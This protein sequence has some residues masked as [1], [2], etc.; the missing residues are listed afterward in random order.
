MKRKFHLYRFVVLDFLAALIAWILFYILRKKIL[1]EGYSTPDLRLL[2]N[3]LLIGSFWL[4]VYYFFG[5]YSEIYRKS[6]IKE[7]FLMMAVSLLGSIVLFFTLMLDDE[8]VQQYQ[9]YYK[10]FTAYFLLHYFIT[11]IPKVFLITFVKNQV[12]KKK[13][14]FNTILIGSGPKALDIYKEIENSFET[15]GL[16]FLAYLP[17]S[18]EYGSFGNTLRCLG[19]LSRLETILSRTH[20][21]Q[22][23]LAVEPEEYSYLKDILFRL[24]QHPSIRIS[25]ISDIHQYLLGSIR[26]NHS[27]DIPL[28][29]VNQDL[30]PEWQANMKRIS[31]VIISALVMLLGMPFFLL[32]GLIIK[33]TSKGPVLYSQ[34]RIGKDGKPF[35][36]F[37]FRS[38]RVD[39]EKNGPALTQEKDNRITGIGNFM[40][41]TRIDEFPQFYNVF[42]GDMSLVGPRPERQFF[43]DQ[44]VKL[45]PHYKHLHKVRPGITSLGQVKYGYAKNV[46]E[47]IARLKYDIVYIE[48]MSFAMDLRILLYTVLVMVQGRGK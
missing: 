2:G 44:I 14:F 30:M 38:M 20:T 39:A 12:K 25:I 33:L 21:E 11:I 34:E 7:I 29:D 19:D 10:T 6:R 5:F 40:R 4:L 43:I 16:K 42:I 37:K 15:L 31:D 3:A 1:G 17:V 9:A 48:N 46:E 47:M 36:I 8:G 18:K 41:K 24:E 27:F 45:A 32:I 13:L 28:M 23:V 26:V 35:M 22:V